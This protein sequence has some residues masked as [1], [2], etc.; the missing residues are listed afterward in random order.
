MHVK[1]SDGGSC[2]PR[3]CLL[4]AFT[5]MPAASQLPITSFKEHLTGRDALQLPDD[6]RCLSA[7]MYRKPVPSIAVPASPQTPL[8]DLPFPTDKD[9]L[10]TTRNAVSIWEGSVNVRKI[11]RSV[12]DCVGAATRSEAGLLAVADGRVVVVEAKGTTRTR[13]HL[14]SGDGHIS[15]LAYANNLQHLFFS[16]TLRHAVQRYSI[17]ED[18]LLDWFCMHPSPPTVLAISASS[19]YAISASRH[20]PTIYLSI[21]GTQ[22]PKHLLVR[23]HASVFGITAASF[24]PET[25][26][27]F[28]LAYADGTVSLHT[29]SRIEVLHASGSDGSIGFLKRAHRVTNQSHYRHAIKHQK[30]G[31]SVDSAQIGAKS[32]SITAAAFVNGCKLRVV[33]VA[34]DGKCRMID[35]ERGAEILRTWS[36]AS[37]CTSLAIYS[38]QNSAAGHVSSRHIVAIGRVRSR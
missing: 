11:Y 6:G 10:V 12:H 28:L 32:V 36:C 30:G 19:R 35:F 21:L 33:T 24:H 34:G 3:H 37:A 27:Y 1:T 16:T 31:S 22:E 15:V 4:H 18:R 5:R 17:V 23:P 14:N 29:A 8:P 2:R 26:E 25:E 38:P 9:L 7:T 20:P 13:Y